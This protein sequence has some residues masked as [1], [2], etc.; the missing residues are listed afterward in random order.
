MY[1]SLFCLFAAAFFGLANSVIAQSHGPAKNLTLLGIPSA[2]VAPNGT[3]FLSLSGTNRRSSTARDEDG[4][5]A[6]GAGFGNAE[7]GIGFQLTGHVTSLTS[8]FGDSGYFAVKAAKRVSQGATPIYVG[9]S[10]E[11]L[12]K[13]GD[14]KSVDERGDVIVSVFPQLTLGNGKTYPVMLSFGVGSDRRG[15]TDVGVFAGAGIGLSET[16]G[17]SAAWT[18]EDVS[19]GVSLRPRTM[20]NLNL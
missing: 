14:V 5:I 16:V 17:V 1:K 15:G 18:G 13:W 11:N 7:Q 3:A 4:S 9:V 12:L 8:S 10:V 20:N 2:T 19:F 6:F